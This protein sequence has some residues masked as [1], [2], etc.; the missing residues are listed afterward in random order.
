[1]IFFLSY[2]LATFFIALNLS[3]MVTFTWCSQGQ[4]RGLTL[5]FLLMLRDSL[6]HLGLFASFKTIILYAAPEPI[7]LTWGIYFAVIEVGYM[8]A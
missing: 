5:C 4:K 7:R 3:E 6:L 8:H 2:S 1:M